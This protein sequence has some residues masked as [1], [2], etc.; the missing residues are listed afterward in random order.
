MI[1]PL[2]VGIEERKNSNF[3]LTNDTPLGCYKNSLL[4]ALASSSALFN[5]ISRLY[6]ENESKDSFSNQ[7][8][9]TLISL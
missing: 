6:Q 8:S 2:P 5:Q 7:L 1:S 3:F 4:Q 9:D